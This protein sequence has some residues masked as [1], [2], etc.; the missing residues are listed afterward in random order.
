MIDITTISDMTEDQ[1]R[2]ALTGAADDISALEAERD[3]FKEEN[4][5]LKADKTKLNEELANT[6][7]L[8]FTLAR[9]LDTGSQSESAEDILSKMFD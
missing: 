1:L 4:E 5:T 7:K 6:K 2:Q 8:N 3:S 9:K